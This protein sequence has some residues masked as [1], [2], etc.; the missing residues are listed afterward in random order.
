MA[1]DLNH[2]ELAGASRS[3]AAGDAPEAILRRYLIDARGGRGLGFYADATAPRAIFRDRGDRLT[4]DRNDPNAVRHMTEI[5]RHRGWTT[6]TVR[7]DTD[8]R[9]EAW[10]AAGLLGLEVR[11]YRPTERDEQALARR[12]DRQPSP[13][14]RDATDG[15]QARL[16]VI[17]RVVRARVPKTV[18]Q[19]RILAAARERLARWLERGAAFEALREVERPSARR[20]RSR[21]RF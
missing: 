14:T 1:D 2:L 16:G 9:R 7:G 10:M 6:I 15:A 8:F 5:A 18:D 4:T 19:E 11:G 3:I 13:M 12:R 20:E 17:D 21:A